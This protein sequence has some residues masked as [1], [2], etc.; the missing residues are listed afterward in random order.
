[1]SADNWTQ[2]PR[3]TRTGEAELSAREVEIVNS[4]GDHPGHFGEEA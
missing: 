1:M 2:C 4:Y 3:C